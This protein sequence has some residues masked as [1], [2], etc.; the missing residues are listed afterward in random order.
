MSKLTK[1]GIRDLGG[2]RKIRVSIDLNDDYQVD[3]GVDGVGGTVLHIQATSLGD[4]IN[5]GREAVRSYM[6]DGVNQVLEVRRR[7]KVLWNHVYGRI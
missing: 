1:Q 2:N 4:A 3:V 7:G 5:Q 6:Y